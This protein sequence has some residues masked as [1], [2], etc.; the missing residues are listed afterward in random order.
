MKLPKIFKPKKN[1]ENLTKSLIK[2]SPTV[3]KMLDG[4]E[5][6]LQNKKNKT[7]ENKYLQGELIAKKITYTKRE[8]EELSKVIV[9]EQKEKGPSNIYN[10]PSIGIYLSALVNKVIKNEDMI[11]LSVSTEFSGLGSYMKQGVVIV[12][13]DLGDYTCNN[14]EGGLM[15]VKGN[16]KGNTANYM[17]G[18]KLMIDGN[19]G[20]FTGWGMKKGEV[21]IEGTVSHISPNCK[22]KIYNKDELIWPESKE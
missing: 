3:L 14:M 12:R 10:D 13:G 18:G 1:L 4:C 19:V 16:T 17:S 6:F 21:Y 8:L 15:V 7:F 22:G 20:W 9:L 11:M 5:E 2:N